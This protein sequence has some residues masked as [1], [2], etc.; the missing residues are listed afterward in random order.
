MKATYFNL[1]NFR[2]V[3]YDR[4]CNLQNSMACHLCDIYIP[5]LYHSLNTPTVSQLL[6]VALQ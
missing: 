4:H 1:I 6:A 2:H 3:L 5:V